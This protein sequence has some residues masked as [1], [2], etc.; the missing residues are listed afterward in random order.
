MPGVLGAT[1]LT[2]QRNR[3]RRYGLFDLLFRDGESIP[4]AAHRDY[5]S[6][7]EGV[8]NE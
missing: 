3:P 4:P 1:V 8:E 5:R 6:E 7:L 2:D